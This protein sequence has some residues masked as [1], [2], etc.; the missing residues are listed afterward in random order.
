M[1]GSAAVR[2]VDDT[3]LFLVEPDRPRESVPDVGIHSW[4][5]GSYAPIGF[6]R[7]APIVHF[8][9]T[10]LAQFLINFVLHYLLILGPATVTVGACAVVALV[11]GR[12]AFVRWL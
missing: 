6:Y 4:P 2:Q 12:R 8:T 3:E 1:S 5:F 11:L 7:P 10:V 9:G